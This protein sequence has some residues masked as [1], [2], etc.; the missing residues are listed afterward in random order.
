MVSKKILI[1]GVTASGKGSLAFE[2]ATRLGGEII[3]VDSMKV[4]RRMDI[5]TAKPPADKRRQMS[6]HL[7]DVVEPSEA[8]SVDRFLELTAAAAGQIQAAGKQ[9]VA[10]GGTA[11]YIK[12]LL[13]G[14]F[15]GPASDAEIRRRLAEQIAQDGLPAMHRRLTQIDPA[16]AERIHPNDQRRIVRALEVFELTGQPIT[17]LQKQWETDAAE[18]WFVIGLRRPK[19]IEST[20]INSRV[21]RMVDEGLL[22]EVK[23]LLAE[24]QPLSKQ[25]RAAIG[26]AE[27]IDHLEGKC[28]YEEAVEQIKINTRKFAKAQRTWFK[29]FRNVRWIDINESD[30][31]QTVT[32]AAIHLWNNR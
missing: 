30:T 9:V 26:Y 15:E 20:R 8:F 4:Y 13:H 31:L 22:E 2:L 6:Y 23:G 16:A 5:G 12:A 1:L 25:A 10:V 21:K 18:D 32:E 27:V 3:S 24:P 14:L 19:E 11:M 17:A 28:S 7:I 29:T